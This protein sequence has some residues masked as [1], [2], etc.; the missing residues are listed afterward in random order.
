MYR[1]PHG[2]L[3]S[4]HSVEIAGGGPTSRPFLKSPHTV[5]STT[6]EKT[7]YLYEPLDSCDFDCFSVEKAKTILLFRRGCSLA[8]LVTS[9]SEKFAETERSAAKML[10]N[11]PTWLMQHRQTIFRR[12][13]FIHIR[14]HRP[15]RELVYGIT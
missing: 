4:Y 1:S 6:T 13:V 11:F 15:I 5:A 7:G 12:S 10:I 14:H 9:F 8:A 3:F 2:S